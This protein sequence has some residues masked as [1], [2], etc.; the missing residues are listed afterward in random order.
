[1]TDK[2]ENIEAVEIDEATDSFHVRSVD[3]HGNDK[4][5]GG[6]HSSLDSAMSVAKK[7]DS[8]KPAGHTVD[9]VQTH[10]KANAK[11]YHKIKAFH[12]TS[13]KKSRPGDEDHIHP[14]HG[15]SSGG[16]HFTKEE[17]E[18]DEASLAMSSLHP[19][20]KPAGTDPKSRIEMM[21][22][23][24]RGIDSMPKKDFIKWFDGQ[25]SLFGPNKDHGVGDKS[26]ANQASIDMKGGK[27]PKTKYPMPK[28]SVKE[29]VEEIFSGSEL[30]EEFKDKASTLFEAAVT[31]RIIAETARLEEE[32]EAKLVEAVEEINEELTSKVDAYLDYVVESWMEE[33]QVAIQSTLRS[34]VME[35]FIEGM[36]TLFAEH[37]I[38]MPEDKVDVV[39]SLASKVEELEGLLDEKITENVEMKRALVETEKDKVFESYVSDLAMSQQDKFAALAESIDFDGDLEVYAKK[40]AIIKEN[41]FGEKKAPQSTNITEETFEAAESTATVSFDP[42]VNRYVQAISRSVKK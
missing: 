40:L 41:Y 14:K 33:N 16:N 39:E 18:I 23:V 10:N 22:S 19:N 32:F 13:G 38:D 1:M 20:S 5:H 26:A 36:K 24:I 9:V 7:L 15:L 6:T 2:R 37:Y 4:M 27:G 25:Q 3:Q 31:A 28:L 8:G 17:V 29:D 35:D 42:S 11:G 12:S 21:L 30:S 34:E